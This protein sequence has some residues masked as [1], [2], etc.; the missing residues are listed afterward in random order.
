MIRLIFQ[1]E[2]IPR[3]TTRAQWR[4]IDRWRRVTEK[5]LRGWREEQSREIG[6]I[7]LAGH[8]DLAARMAERLINPAVMIYPEVLS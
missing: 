8:R 1:P 7:A 3:T 6:Q 2:R 4:E 5:R